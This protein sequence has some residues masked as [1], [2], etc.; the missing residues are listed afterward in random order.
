VN[1]SGPDHERRYTVE[2]MVGPEC[3]GIG[4]GNSKQAAEQSA[5][6]KALEKIDALP[7]E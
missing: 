7:P 3:Y 5:A 4:T 1:M 6:R 2:V